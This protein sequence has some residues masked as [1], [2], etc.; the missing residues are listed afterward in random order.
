MKR[1]ILRRLARFL[2][3]YA[4]RLTLCLGLTVLSSLLSLAAPL[5]SG[6]AVDAVGTVPGAVDFPGVFR[7]CGG[8]LACYA[9]SSLLSYAVSARIIKVGQ[10][11]SRDLRKAA[12][13]RMSELPVEYFDT[14]PAGDL[15]SRVCYDVDTVNAAISTDLLHLCTS[16]L[17]VGGSFLMLLAISPRLTCVFFVTVPLSL[18]LT[19]FQMRR[20]HPLFRL[21]SRELGALNSFAEERVGRQRAIRAYGV[22]AADL[23]QF[24]AYNAAASEA[25]YEADRASASLGPSVN[26]INN[27]SLAA[28]S[29]FGALLY[30][31]GGL[32]LG[33]LSSFVLYSRKFSSPI[34][35]AANLLSELQ[36]SAAAAERVLDLLDEQPEPGDIP[37]AVEPEKLWGDISFDHVDF[38]YDPDRPVLRD[39]TARIPAGSLAAV[40]GP[41]GAGKTTLVSLL[42]RFY[43]PQSG[44]ISIDGVPLEEYT[45]DGLRRRLALVLQDT[46]LFGGTIAENIA[47]GAQGASREQIVEAAKAARVHRFITSL[48]QGYDTVLADEGAGI[49]KGQRQLLAIARCFLTGADIVILDEATSSV[50]TE[51]EGEVNLAVERLRQGRTCFVIAHRLATVRRADCILV[52]DQGGVAEAGTHQE[53]LAAG[54]V[55]ASLSRAAE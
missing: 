40:V 12:F 29:M 41:T 14:H 8:M 11:V 37:G 30:L 15:V 4:L 39:F 20:I 50:D 38:G 19:R 51:T 3:P 28:V 16:A 32:T 23:E 36:S 47:Y 6:R 54:G 10:S 49:S 55:Y 42:L 18:F 43:R 21:R 13:D 2:R 25:Y 53:L 46:W 52:L 33:N 34:R 26:F 35:E 9:L 5:L 17:T 1:H 31:G 22:E 44:S 27:L 48:P 7:A 24:Q 45:R